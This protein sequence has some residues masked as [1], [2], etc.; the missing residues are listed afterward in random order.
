MWPEEREEGHVSASWHA[1]YRFIQT[2]ATL[3][4]EALWLM[5]FPCRMGWLVPCG[6]RL[7]SRPSRGDRE[8]YRRSADVVGRFHDEHDVILAEGEVRDFETRSQFFEER[9]DDIDTVLR[10]LELGGP[11][12]R[13]VGQLHEVVS[14]ERLPSWTG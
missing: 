8:R 2:R 12:F 10:V 3:T 9:A 6:A 14:H 1:S 7:L 13:S 5:P 11:G 4:G